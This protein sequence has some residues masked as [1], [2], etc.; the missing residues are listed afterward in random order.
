MGRATPLDPH[1]DE[2][3]KTIAIYGA[4]AQVATDRAHLRAA[5]EEDVIISARWMSLAALAQDWTPPEFPLSG[6]DLRTQGVEAGPKMGKI[7]DALKALWVKSGFTA[8]REKL[9]MAL[10]LINR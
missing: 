1:A 7:L 6:K 3:A 5:G 9:L 10:K 4:G 8:V 2:R